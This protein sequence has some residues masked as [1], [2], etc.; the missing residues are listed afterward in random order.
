MKVIKII[1]GVIVAILVI[2]L[3][4]AFFLPTDYVVEREITIQAP[5]DTLFSYLKYVKNQDEFSVWSQMDPN[6]K[7]EYRG[8]DGTVGFV[9]AWDS[10]HEQV[11]KGEQEIINIKEGERIDFELRFFEPFES[12]GYAYF[13]TTALDSATTRVIWGFK[14]KSPYPFNLMLLLWDM[15]KMLGGD[16]EKGLANLKTLWESKDAVQSEDS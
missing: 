6:M 12:K 2:L 4:V 9:S 14:G 11:G 5:K 16:L 13:I 7:K 3:V 8:T 10:D 15:D 1:L